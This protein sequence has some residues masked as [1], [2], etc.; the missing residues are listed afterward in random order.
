MRF[1]V[2]LLLS[3]LLVAALFSNVYAET[4]QE[5][6][7]RGYGASLSGNIE[8][9]ISC[10]TKALQI[11]PQNKYAYQIRAVTKMETGDLKG[12]LSDYNK[13]IEISPNFTEA[14]IG[15]GRTKE[16]LGDKKGAK[17]DF[18]K[19]EDLRKR[20]VDHALEDINKEIEADPKAAKK[21]L[22]RGT[23]KLLERDYKGA[24]KDFNRY[25]EIVGRPKNS[26]VYH[27]KARSLQELGDIQGAIDTYSLIINVFPI[28][29][30]AYELR[31][32]LREKIGDK[33]GAISD[34]STMQEMIREKKRQKNDEETKY[35]EKYPNSYDIYRLRAQHRA[36]LGEYE[37][38][39]ADIEKAIEL[40][41]D[42]KFLLGMK[43]KKDSILREM[44]KKNEDQQKRDKIDELNKFIGKHPDSFPSYKDRAKLKMQLGEN[45]AA[46]GDIEKAM[47]LNPDDRELQ[48][49]KETVLLRINHKK[50]VLERMRKSQ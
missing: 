2:R 38:A 46:L 27:S 13:A 23:Y 4:A 37:A 45:E 25:L 11:D 32:S 18:E 30:R 34:L 48:L 44:H 42:D 24:V 39:L 29:L 20:G 35:L 1:T 9:A 21:I 49:M 47:D 33:A 8:E 31:A 43:S 41:P 16:R 17:A 28:D 14:Y 26:G 40:A 36:E 19:A 15:R 50:K 10:Y 5:W 12:A 7:Q 3:I 6:I 22:D